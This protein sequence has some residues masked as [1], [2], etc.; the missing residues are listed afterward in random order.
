MS[1]NDLSGQFLTKI[2]SSYRITI[3]LEIRELLELKPGDYIKVTIKV[4]KKP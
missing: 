4:V 1:G 2:P 3:P